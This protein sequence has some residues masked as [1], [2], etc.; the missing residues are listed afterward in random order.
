MRSSFALVLAMALAA[1]DL[2]SAFEAVKGAQAEV[3]AADA[4][5]DLARFKAARASLPPLQARFKELF[6]AADWNALD[7]VK[8]RELLGGGLLT[9]GRDALERGDGKTAVRA[10]EMVLSKLGKEPFAPAVGVRHLPAAYVLAGEASKAVARWDA[11]A[12]DPDPGVAA[13]ANLL[14]GDLRCALGDLA[15]AKTAWKKAADA[16]VTDPAK[17]PAAG[18]KADAVLRLALVGNPAPEIESNSWFGGEKSTLSRQKG[19]VVVLEFFSTGNPTS[20]EGLAGLDGLF[21]A[22]RARGLVVLGVTH[23]YP[24]GFLPR[25]GTREPATDGEP[26]RD[27]PEDDY[28]A[29]LKRF[30]EN[31][32]VAFP[33]VLAEQPA[34]DA[35]GVKAIPFRAVLDRD[36]TVAWFR[37]G[38]GDEAL[39]RGVVKRL[40]DRK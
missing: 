21:A 7:P 16:K 5:K 37:V 3:A 20:R 38:T 10:F 34:Y 14:L 2:H 9:A 32:G 29:H 33:L 4:A 23:Y 8:D 30:R 39:F 6:A 27:I 31:L 25:R 22:E 26:V 35:Y 36:G 40:L 24:H 18:P 1:D 12:A 11:C 15:A 28:P 17:D 13:L 19:K